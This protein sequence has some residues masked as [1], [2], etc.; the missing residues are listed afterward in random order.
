MKTLIFCT[1]WVQLESYLFG[2]PRYDKWVNYYE[3]VSDQFGAQ[4]LCLID[5]GSVEP[6][7]ID[8]HFLMAENLPSSLERKINL[9]HFEEHL[10]RSSTETYPGWW[11]SFLFSIKVARQYGFDKIIHIE[12][13]CFIFSKQLADFIKNVESG[14]VSLYCHYHNWPETSVQVICRD[15][16]DQLEKLYNKGYQTGFIFEDFAERLLPF[17]QVEKKFFGDRY[18]EL[19]IFLNLQNVI[20]IPDQIDYIAQLPILLRL[21][22]LLNLND[23]KASNN[24]TLTH[25]SGKTP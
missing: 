25:R 4:F 3:S 16:F 12:S 2:K 1:C 10:G 20:F 21:E 23:L 7:L 6:S 11:R 15:Q 9:I 19:P 13:D 24:V 22:T 14:W 18:G 5:D 8:E 17:T